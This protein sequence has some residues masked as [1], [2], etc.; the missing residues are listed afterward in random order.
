M[1]I[2]T[3]GSAFIGAGIVSEMHGRAIKRNPTSKLIGVFDQKKPKAAAIAKKFG[4]R[5][6]K[7]INELLDDPKVE[8]VHI[9]APLRFHLETAGDVWPPASGRARLQSS[10]RSS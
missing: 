6:Y 4:G 9:L 3:V 8:L 1:A 7:S 2:P 5:A 10:H